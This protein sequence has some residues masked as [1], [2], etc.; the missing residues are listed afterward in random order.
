M[1]G[2]TTAVKVNFPNQLLENLDK[3]WPK[4]YRTRHAAILDAVSRRVDELKEA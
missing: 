2:K 4:K 1:S 3:L